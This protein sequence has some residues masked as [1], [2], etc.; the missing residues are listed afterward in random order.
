MLLSYGIRNVPLVASLIVI[1]ID[2]PSILPSTSMMTA[3][4]LSLNDHNHNPETGAALTQEWV[5]VFFNS[6]DSK[7]SIS[8]CLDDDFL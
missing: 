6:M 7:N 2:W 1:S 5:N 8:K 3:C 4:P